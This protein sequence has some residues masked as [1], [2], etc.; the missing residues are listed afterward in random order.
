MIC[1][2]TVTFSVLLLRFLMMM[3]MLLLLLYLDLGSS[4]PQRAAFLFTLTIGAVGGRGSR[5]KTV[6]MRVSGEAG[7]SLD[8]A[9]IVHDA[10]I[11]ARIARLRLSGLADG[12]EA[13]GTLA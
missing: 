11:T 8:A 13:A 5:K 9:I 6:R 3:M 2:G 12:T 10:G 1:G 7:R 4:S